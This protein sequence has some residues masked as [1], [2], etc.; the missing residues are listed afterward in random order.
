MSELDTEIA[1]Y[2]LYPLDLDKSKTRRE[3]IT[4]YGLSGYRTIRQQCVIEKPVKPSID[5]E[6]RCYRQIVRSLTELQPLHTLEGFNERAWKGKHVDHITSIWD[7]YYNG[8][9]PE[10]CAD[11]SNLRMLPYRDNLL[12]GR[13]SG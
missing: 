5:K 1:F 9:E 3:L 13:K 8:W 10:R 4:K 7:A 12:K 2:K 6:F 11:I